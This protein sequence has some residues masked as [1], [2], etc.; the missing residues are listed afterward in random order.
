M[1]L[2]FNDHEMSMRIRFDEPL[3]DDELPRFSLDNDPWRVERDASGELIM[4]T[5][6]T[7]LLHEP[8]S[9]Q[10]TGPVADFELLLSRI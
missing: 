10:G 1:N 3:S 8:T 7:A 4:M 6:S 5:P 2:A 9:V